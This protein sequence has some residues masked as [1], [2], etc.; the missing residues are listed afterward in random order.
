MLIEFRVKNFRSLRD[1]QVLS[2]LASND[3]TLR[4]THSHQT[5]IKAAPHVL[6]SAVIY[7]ANASGKSNLLRALQYMRGVVLESAARQP[8]QLY[9]VQPFRL[10][11]QT[12]QQASAFEVIFL[13]QGVR[14]QY[15]FSMNQQAILDEYLFVYKAFKPQLWFRR[16]QEQFEYGSSF[17]GN[18]KTWQ[19]STRPDNL[20][21]SV[22]VQLNSDML[23]PVFDWFAG[24]L[25]IFNEFSQLNPMFS[26]QELQNPEQA[27]RFCHFLQAA[28]ISLAGI[29]V[30]KSKTGQMMQVVQINRAT[31][32]AQVELQET[33]QFSS[34]HKV[35]NQ[36]ANFEWTDESTGTRNLITL[37]GP[38][39]YILQKGRVLVVDELDSSLHPHLVQELVR[40]FHDP[41]R[42]P[43]GA[44]LI[45]TT[46]DAS[47]L[48]VV[49]LFRRDQIWFTE[50]QAD[51]SSRLYS[52]WDQFSPRKN[53]SLGRAYLQGRYGAVPILG[54][55]GQ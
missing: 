1:E 24:D 40:L 11:S 23:K 25:H 4:D 42:N 22:A 52:L 26:W 9:N 30:E 19:T 20:F 32:Q 13:H 2:L 41:Q 53:E 33:L 35:G 6:H 34:K 29:T 38:I 7:G 37:Y 10:D 14:Y 18:K 51:Q 16:N 12:S 54:D 43:H 17:K 48:D 31:G 47:L 27:Q 44:Q 39:Q 28:D 55:M 45:F 15:G 3:K 36:E 49:G 21:L 8:N 50:K 46:H 5:G